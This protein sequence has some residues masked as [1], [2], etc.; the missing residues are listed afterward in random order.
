MAD[1]NVEYRV[2]ELESDV[3][4][5]KADVKL[6]LENHLPHINIKIAVLICQVTLIMGA[7]GVLLKI[8]LYP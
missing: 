6:I 5:I 2:G 3:K 1:D 7:V 8:A 4:G